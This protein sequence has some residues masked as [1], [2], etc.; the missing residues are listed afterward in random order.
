MGPMWCYFPHMLWTWVDIQRQC[1]LVCMHVLCCTSRR[2]YPWAKGIIMCVHAHILNLYTII[3]EPVH[4]FYGPV[5][6]DPQT[7]AHTHVLIVFLIPQTSHPPW[8]CDHMT[9]T[10]PPWP[11]APNNKQVTGKLHHTCWN[12]YQ[13]VCPTGANVISN[14]SNP[15]THLRHTYV[16]RTGL[17]TK[18]AQSSI[19]NVNLH[20]HNSSRTDTLFVY[21]C[22]P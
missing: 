1:F 9:G 22:S 17:Y 13:T 6:H 10:S 20:P 21:Y 7:H 12:A 3:H 15:E 5:R 8:T 18:H 16:G 4:R 2:M 14:R 11:D 19:N